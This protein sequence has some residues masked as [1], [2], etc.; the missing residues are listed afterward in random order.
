MKSAEAT[1]SMMRPR[2]VEPARRGAELE[3]LPAALEVLETPASPAGRTIG[4]IIILFFTVALGWATFGHVD[5][6][7]TAQGKIVPTGRTK[8]IQPLEPGVVTAILVEDGDHVASGQVLVELD[9]T[10]STA[11][12][13]H[14]AQDLLSARLDVARLSALR[15]GFDRGVGPRDFE[16]PGNASAAQ[17][18]QARATMNRA[19][20]GTRSEGRIYRPA[21]R[22]EERGGRRNRGDDC[23]A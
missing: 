13:N 3:F 12:R 6:I 11:E 16:P 7:A 4:A 15:V 14:V 20:G 22:A 21:D 2:P 17:V 1:G 5:I 23:Q 10:V 8:V 18:A 9:R 19:S